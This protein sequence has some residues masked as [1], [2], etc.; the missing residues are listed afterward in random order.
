MPSAGTV[1]AQTDVGSTIGGESA[2]AYRWAGVVAVALTI[3]FPAG[4]A[5]SASGAASL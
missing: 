3:L 5:D 1:L 4:C 2:R